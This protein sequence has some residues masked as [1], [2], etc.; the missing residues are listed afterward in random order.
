[1]KKSIALAALIMLSSSFA[2]TKFITSK[3]LD[4]KEN[5]CETS[6]DVFRSLM[7]SYTGSVTDLIKEDD[8]LKVTIALEFKKCVASEE[9]QNF[10]SMRPYD[11]FTVELSNG[12]S[13]LMTPLDVRLK[14]YQDGVFNILVDKKLGTSDQ[15]EVVLT[16]PLSQ[17]KGEFDFMVNKK[18]QWENEATGEKKSSARSFGAYRVKY[19]VK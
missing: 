15:Q 2:E 12:V 18:M 8:S 10:V 3:I 13:Y 9:G 17:K 6:F 7:G 14:V 1:M 5:R 4:G 19:Q 16:L 11:D